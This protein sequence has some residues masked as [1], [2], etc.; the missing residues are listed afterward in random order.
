MNFRDKQSPCIRHLSEIPQLNRPLIS[1]KG[2]GPKRAE[3]LA[4]RGLHTLLDLLLFTPIRYEDRRKVT[5]L[6]EA[7]EGQ[8]VLVRGKVV[9]GREERFFRSRKRLLR[10]PDR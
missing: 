3:L 9:S 10:A 1:L 6:S 8:P 5:V 7:K 4:E 2:I